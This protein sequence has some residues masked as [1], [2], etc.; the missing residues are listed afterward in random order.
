MICLTIFF[1]FFIQNTNNDQEAAGH[2]DDDDDDLGLA[3]DEEY[4]HSIEVFLSI[5]FFYI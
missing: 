5:E 2:I 3:N 4:L 1:A